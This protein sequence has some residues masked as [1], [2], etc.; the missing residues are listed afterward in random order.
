M[1]NDRQQLLATV[2]Q[3]KQQLD[4]VQGLDPAT[5]ARLRATLADLEVALA[6]QK[7]ALQPGLAE[8]LGQAAREFEE[9][10]PILAGTVGSVIDALARMGI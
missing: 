5:Q 9:S 3:L 4:E 7:P 10:H 8:R 6:N 2:A 1:P